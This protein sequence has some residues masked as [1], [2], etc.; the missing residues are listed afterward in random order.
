MNGRVSGYPIFS[1]EISG[2]SDEDLTA[3]LRP[4]VPGSPRRS[5]PGPRSDR[6]APSLEGSSLDPESVLRV[7]V[8]LVENEVVPSEVIEYSGIFI[9]F[10]YKQEVLCIFIAL[11]IFIVPCDELHKSQTRQRRNSYIQYW[12][13]TYPYYHGFLISISEAQDIQNDRMLRGPTYSMETL[14]NAAKR[15]KI[16]QLC[17]EL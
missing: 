11:R 1:S 14:G 2:N 16:D 6:P 8:F 12:A 13:G 17:P 10:H 5:F 3:G 7:P 9:F 15:D 4:W